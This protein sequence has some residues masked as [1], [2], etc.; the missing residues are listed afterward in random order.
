[1][2]SLVS[3]VSS[4]S[5]L[6]PPINPRHMFVL[7][8]QEADLSTSRILD[9]AFHPHVAHV[10]VKSLAPIYAAGHHKGAKKGQNLLDKA[11]TT[12]IP[13]MKAFRLVHNK[14]RLHASKMSK[15]LGISMVSTPGW[16][17]LPDAETEIDNVSHLMSEQVVLPLESKRKEDLKMVQ[18]N[19]SSLLERLDDS[20]SVVHFACHGRTKGSTV[21]MDESALVLVREET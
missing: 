10:G 14:Q 19:V 5:L 7:R 15:F 4:A 17:S 18:P 6:V 12:Y 2:M 13:S 9:I 3:S 20:C 11:L 16:R 8:G 21:T 1:M